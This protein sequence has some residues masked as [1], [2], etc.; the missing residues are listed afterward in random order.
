MDRIRK[1]L[2]HL[3][4]ESLRRLLGG[5]NIADLDY[6]WDDL[7]EEEAI[8]IFSQLDLDKKVD[9]VNFLPA[10]DQE[11]VAGILETYDLI[12]LPVIDHYNRLLGI[13]TFDDIIDVIRKEHTEDV[14]KMGAMSRG[15]ERY[16]DSSILTLVKKR[17][18]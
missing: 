1:S 12:A 3:S 16:L 8:R 10:P 9:L 18:P 13:I 11:E 4:N 6:V 2:A 14:Y 7:D 5:I 17:I 15:T